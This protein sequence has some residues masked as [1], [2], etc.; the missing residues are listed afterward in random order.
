PSIAR[1]VND[2]ADGSAREQMAHAALLSGMALA[3]SG[4]GLAHGVAAA[5]GVHCRVAHGLACAV[6]LPAA[7][8]VNRVVA[9][10]RIARLAPVITGRNWSNTQSAVDAC[11]Q[12]IHELCRTVGIPQTLTEIGVVREQL[13]A[14]VASS[15]GN[16]M[17]GNPRE[18]SDEEL[19]D[20]LES[21]M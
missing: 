2:P 21:L 9:G 5:L 11:V 16:S 18:M 19:S 17:H 8:R 13:P 4:L 3:N 20:L 15:R 10:E 6:M 1:V 12:S 14:L 7:M